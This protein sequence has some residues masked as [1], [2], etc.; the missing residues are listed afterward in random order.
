MK[1]FVV[2]SALGLLMVPLLSYAAVSADGA[3]A[4][5]AIT[6]AKEDASAVVTIVIAIG[7]VLAAAGVILR[8]MRK[9]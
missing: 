3:A 1:K 6:Q 7:A 8:V 5:S 9:A 2:L 4:V